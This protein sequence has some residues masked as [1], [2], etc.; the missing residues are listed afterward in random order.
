VVP[1]F[2][3]RQ[4]LHWNMTC[5]GILLQVVQDRPAQHVGQENIERYCGGV[6]LP[7]QREG[8]RPAGG[9][10][11]LETLI[12]GQITQDPR[13]VRIIFYNQ[14]GGIVELQIITVVLNLLNRNLLD[15][16]I[17]QLGR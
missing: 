3:E 7:H 4:H 13:V 8:L 11:N 15:V 10:Q 5:A 16:G 14:Q 1:V 9:H 12:A 2:I 17:G 6:E